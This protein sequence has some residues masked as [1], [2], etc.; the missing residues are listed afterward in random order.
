MVPSFRQGH[1]AISAL[2]AVLILSAE[3][4]VVWICMT[5]RRGFALS[6]GY[7]HGELEQMTSRLL[8]RSQVTWLAQ[9]IGTGALVLWGKLTSKS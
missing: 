2:A 1:R 6:P 5:V 7:A 8:A 3:Q 9:A 4:E